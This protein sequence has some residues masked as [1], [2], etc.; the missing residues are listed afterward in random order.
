MQALGQT[1][2][3]RGDEIDISS[4]NVSFWLQKHFLPK[5]HH[6]IYILL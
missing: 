4:L 1:Y 2:T 6:Q 5:F 3:H